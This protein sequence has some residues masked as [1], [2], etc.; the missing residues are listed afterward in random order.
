VTASLW[1]GIVKPYG[2]GGRLHGRQARG[3][4]PNGLLKHHRVIHFLVPGGVEKR[5]ALPAGACAKCVQQRCMGA[6]L[7]KLSLTERGPAS[8]FVRGPF[9]QL[10]SGRDIGQP[11]VEGR[12]LLFDSPWPEPIHEYAIAVAPDR[13]LVDSFAAD[14]NVRGGR[15]LRLEIAKTV[16]SC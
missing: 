16:V 9:S 14:I 8:R 5:H 13:L 1:V 6:Q 7:Q 10:G 2:G 3:S 4:C 15:E 11:C 12:R